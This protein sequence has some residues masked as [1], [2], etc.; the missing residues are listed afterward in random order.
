MDYQD[1]KGLREITLKRL[2]T[3]TWY[4]IELK[5]FVMKYDGEASPCTKGK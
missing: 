2:L 5:M 4:R 3:T 1:K